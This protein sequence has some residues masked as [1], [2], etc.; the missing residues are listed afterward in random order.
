MIR[1]I[2]MRGKGQRERSRPRAGRD[3]RVPDAVARKLVN[4]RRRPER[5]YVGIGDF[6]VCGVIPL[7]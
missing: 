6:H 5:I 3:D 4:E 1:D 2:R 7:Q